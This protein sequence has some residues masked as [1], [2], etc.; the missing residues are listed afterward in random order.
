MPTYTPVSEN[1]DYNINS[2]GTILFAASLVALF[3]SL[4]VFALRVYVKACISRKLTPDDWWMV[5]GLVSSALHS[6]SSKNVP[7]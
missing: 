2:G 5:A 6:S 7:L 3:C 1:L 4:G